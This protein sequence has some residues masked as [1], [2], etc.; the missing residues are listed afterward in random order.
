MNANRE[1]TAYNEDG[2]KIT[3]EVL[4]SYQNYNNKNSYIF[5]T[6]NE[7]DEDG[8]LNI[9]ASRYLGENEDGMILEDIED[10]LEWELLEGVIEEV[11]KGVKN[12]G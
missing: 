7:Y 2:F 8:N 11:K 1:F 6:D 4:M 10:D 3:C 12:N 9:F 5:Y